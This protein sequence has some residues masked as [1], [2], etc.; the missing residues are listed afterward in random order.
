MTPS[1]SLLSDEAPLELC[2][3]LHPGMTLVDFAGPQCV[4]GLV[5]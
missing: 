5:A 3:V 4:L 2:V 1:S